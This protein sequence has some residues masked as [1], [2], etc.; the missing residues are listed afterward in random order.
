MQLPSNVSGRTYLISCQCK[1]DKSPHADALITLLGTS[2]EQSRW[3]F[4]LAL[5][6]VISSMQGFGRSVATDQR[7]QEQEKTATLALQAPQ[8]EGHQR[9]EGLLAHSRTEHMHGHHVHRGE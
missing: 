3:R 5:A 7:S 1:V 8:V 4:K 2:T 9:V 6:V